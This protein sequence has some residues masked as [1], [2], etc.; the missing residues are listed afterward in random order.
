M[1]IFTK[2]V[3]IPFVVVFIL[4]V[5]SA[6]AQQKGKKAIK[7]IIKPSIYYSQLETTA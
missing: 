3:L 4:L 7:K 6:C 2:F 5:L 1:S